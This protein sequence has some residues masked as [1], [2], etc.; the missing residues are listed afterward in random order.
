M[1]KIE[2]SIEVN[3]PAHAVY[4]QLTQFEDYPRFMEDVEEVRQLDDT[5]LHWHA[6]MNSHDME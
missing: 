2:Q 6:K 3:V 5:H 1:T 4:N